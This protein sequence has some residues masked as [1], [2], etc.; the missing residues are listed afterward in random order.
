MTLLAFLIGLA[1]GISFWLWQQRQWY[2]QLKKLLGSLPD[3]DGVVSMPVMIRLQRKFSQLIRQSQAQKLELQSQQQLLKE[4]PLGYLLVDAEHQLLWCNQQARQLLNIQGWEQGKLRLLLEVVRSYELDRLVEQTHLKQQPCQR[5]WVFYPVYSEGAAI[6]A[7][8]SLS[9]KASSFPV[10]ENQVAIFIE[11]LQP[12]VEVTAARNRW[13]S[14]LAHE[15]RTPLTS[16]RLV[17]EA[18]QER[19]EPTSKQWCERMI[20]ETDRLANLVAEWLELTQ[21]EQDPSNVIRAKTIT[22][23]YLI[24]SAWQTLEPLAHSKQISL[25]YCEP[26]IIWVNADETRLTQVFL[27]LFD[28]SIKHSPPCSEIRVEVIQLLRD[29][30]KSLPEAA[31]NNQNQNTSAGETQLYREKKITSD[32]TS[33]Q[34][35]IIDS[36]DGFS[37][38]DL[39][40]VFERLYRGDTSRQQPKNALK[41]LKN[42]R[43]SS[44]SGLG[45]SIVQQIIQAHNGEIIARN[46]PQTGGAWLQIKLPYCKN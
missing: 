5:Q 32:Y 8:Q 22:L 6:A 3:D 12:L 14:D 45:L 15:L 28:N 39:P 23:D 46:H 16:I 29:N 2:R 18:L 33:I 19:L 27:N 1:L 37:G 35:D 24:K 44:G 40:Y 17:L 41:D 38:S 20:L 26:E 42:I 7:R 34:I 11:N 36:G 43:S 9:L 30:L 31:S 10:G 21:M 4:M 13:V 25:V